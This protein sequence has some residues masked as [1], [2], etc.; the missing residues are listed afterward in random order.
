[1]YR[2][3]EMVIWFSR[4]PRPVGLP[5]AAVPLRLADPA[6]DR[7]AGAGRLAVGQPADPGPARPLRQPRRPRARRARA[8]SRSRPSG[9]RVFFLDKDT[10]DNKSGKNIFISTIER[11]RADHHLGAQRHASMTEGDS[12][13]LLLSNG[14]RLESSLDGRE[15]ARSASSRSYGNRVGSRRTG[16][17][18]TTRRSRRCSTWPLL[19]E[20]D[21]APTWANWPGASA[22]RSRRST[23][24]V[25][26][27]HGLQRQP[28]RRP[29][30]QP[31]V[32]AVRLRRLLQ[33]AQPGPE[34]DQR[35]PRQLRRLPA[36]AARRRLRARACSGWPSSTTTGLRPRAAGAARRAATA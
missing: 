6:A 26:R 15:P 12:Q 33:P 1:M 28:A 35:R 14:Q 36:G 34:L 21:A 3:S 25:H 11:G 27:G 13:F 23:S 5:A 29:Q 32:R 7:G 20:P 24:C 31:G 19:L 22:W 30:R 18:R 9:T 2:D 8:S 17:R 16:D 10:P 4:R